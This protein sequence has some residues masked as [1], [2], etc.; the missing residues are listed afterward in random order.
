[1]VD[2][3]IVRYLVVD[4]QFQYLDISHVSFST[5]GTYYREPGYFDYL[6]IQTSSPVSP[7]DTIVPF[8]RGYHIRNEILG[9]YIFSL[10]VECT[11]NSG[12]LYYR[13]HNPLNITLA[14]L[15]IGL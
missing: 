12:S 8:I 9:S 4:T 1:M 3:M 5:S 2:R 10:E 13:I 14:A 11:V 6:P 7:T 15:Y